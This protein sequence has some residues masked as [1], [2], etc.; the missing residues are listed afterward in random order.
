MEVSG[1]CQSVTYTAASPHYV[2][3]RQTQ[4]PIDIDAPYVMRV[5][6]KPLYPS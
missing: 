6:L 5:A 4:Q 2:P 1:E 3:T